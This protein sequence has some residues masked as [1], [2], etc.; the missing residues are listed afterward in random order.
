MQTQGICA[1]VLLGPLPKCA[2]SVHL[3]CASWFR[4]SLLNL[5]SF[6]AFTVCTLLQGIN[7]AQHLAPAARPLGTATL[8]LS[9]AL[10][11]PDATST[12]A[13]NVK[14]S[15]HS[16]LGDSTSVSSRH[17]PSLAEAAGPSGSEGSALNTAAGS[18]PSTTAA[19]G[20]LALEPGATQLSLPPA[21]PATRQSTTA[22]ERASSLGAYAPSP[23]H[24][25]QHLVLCAPEDG[26]PV[27]QLSLT[28]RLLRPLRLPPPL[29]A[30]A[31]AP[32]RHTPDPAT[33]T[34]QQLVAGKGGARLLG[35]VQ[36]G[37]AW[38]EEMVIAQADAARYVRRLHGAVYR[39]CMPHKGDV[40]QGAWLEVQQGVQDGERSAR[41]AVKGW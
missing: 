30:S 16:I 20:M 8:P 6:S 33:Q 28:P 15:L 7:V 37:S 32:A 3:L 38:L 23:E 41:V 27:M 10:I 4:A 9:Q 1:V 39:V 31:V 11:S 19:P 5:H 34:Q 17:S 22:G 36:N 21:Q 25:T 14:S 2:I 40:Q 26:S 12:C 35:L 13:H 24:N 18:M 29:L